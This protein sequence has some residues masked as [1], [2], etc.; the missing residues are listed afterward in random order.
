LLVKYIKGERIL[1]IDDRMN[2]KTILEANV[3]Q[4][5]INEYTAKQTIRIYKVQLKKYFQWLNEDP[6]TYIKDVRNMDNGKRLNSI[7]GYEK[8]ITNYRN[9][10]IENDYS[11]KAIHNYVSCVKMFLEHHHIDLDNAFWKKLKKRGI[12]K[13][14]EPIC[15]FK[16]PKPDDL[17][18]ILTHAST[19]S[20]AMFL[21]QS[22][23]GMRIGE[24]CSLRVSDIDLSYDYPHITIRGMVSKTR[25]KGRTR[26]S[27]ETKDAILEWLKIRDN[28]IKVKETRV[29]KKYLPP[30]FKERLFTSSPKSARKMWNNLLK[31]A[32]FMDKDNSG[33]Y[34]RFKMGTHSLRK[35]F[36]NEFS[37]HN[38]DLAKYLANQRTKLDKKYRDWSDEYL[39]EQYAQGV[40]H[41]LIFDRETT[42]ARIKDLDTEIVKLRQD[43]EELRN[44]MQILMAKVLTLDDKEKK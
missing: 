34:E 25:A 44:Q 8:N 30:D 38:N 32:Q 33:K 18:K 39:D 28:E 35:F 5:F 24:I 26:C 11:P 9:W 37:K 13:V 16:I 7:D 31:K 43:N 14:V 3:V 1:N 22:S 36:I 40:K 42:D 4:D 20:R 10:L 27:P 17:K 6:D 41:L 12:E 21:L 2:E 23:S 19:R 29:A 15:D